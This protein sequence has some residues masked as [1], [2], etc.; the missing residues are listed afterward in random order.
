[1]KSS[2]SRAR[3]PW[4]VLMYEG[5][6]VIPPVSSWCSSRALPPLTTSAAAR[7]PS[8]TPEAPRT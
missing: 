7:L 1:L 3:L 8:A 4:R 2:Y 5:Q 6:R